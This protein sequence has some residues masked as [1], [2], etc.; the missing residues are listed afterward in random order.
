MAGLNKKMIPKS[1]R[2]DGFTLI[3][4]LVVIAIVAILAAMLL[5][6]LA[7]AKAKAQQTTCMNKLKQWGLAQTMYAQDNND[8]IPHESSVSGSAL[9]PWSNVANPPTNPDVWYNSLPALIG[10]K[11]ASAYS[12]NA[13]NQKAFY[14][15]NLL[16]HCPS[17]QFNTVSTPNGADAYFTIAMNSKLN[18][19]NTT[20]RTAAVMRSSATVFFLENLLAGDVPVDSKQSTSNLGQPSA[21]ANRFAAR[22]TGNGNLAFFDGHAAGFKGNQVVQC[23][24]GDANEGLAIIPQTQIVWTTDPNDPTLK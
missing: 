24:S 10:L 14:D 17:A 21:Y 9:E 2:R 1:Q 3:E 15:A 5:P 19:G 22:H 16:F 7:K 12:A 4:L 13:A 18:T 23:T 6:A 11:P 20:I 8:Y